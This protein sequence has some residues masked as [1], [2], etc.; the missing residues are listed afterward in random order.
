MSAST[1]PIRLST[2]AL[3]ELPGAVPRPSYDRDALA[4]SIVH[5][6]V[7]GF[8]RAHLATYV[9]EIAAAG[10]LDWGIVGV[11]IM[12]GDRNM[13]DALVPQDGLYT[14]IERGPS[15]TE[16]AVIG[17]IVEYLHVDGKPELLID[18]IADPRTQIVSLTI[19]EG[20]YPIDDVTGDYASDSPNAGPAGAFALIAAGLEARRT[21]HG[22]PITILSCDNIMS[23]GNVTRTSTLGAAAPIGTELLDWIGEAVS[24]PNSMVDRITPQTADSDREWLAATQA[25]ETTTSSSPT[26]SNRTSS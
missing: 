3:P 9:D 10:N 12:A 24:F 23:N 8:H 14:L 21:Q 20:G 6:G 19:T 17:S 15:S 13:A 4:P 11:G 22:A 16:I 2:T 25:I 18:R 26:T 1:Q 7:G 5:I